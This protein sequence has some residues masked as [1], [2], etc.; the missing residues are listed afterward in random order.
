MPETLLFQPPFDAGIFAF[1]AARAVT[2]VEEA[3]G[4][5]YARTL[6][7]PGGHGWFRVAWDG[8]SLTLDHEVEDPADSAGLVCRVRALLDLDHDPLVV[9]LSLIHI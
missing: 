6:A 9:D 2:G 7:L 1:L 5:S 4:S 8:T 3:T